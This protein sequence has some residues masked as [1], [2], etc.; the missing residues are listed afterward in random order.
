MN[1]WCICWFFTNIFTGILNLKGLT[2]RRLYK[3]FGVK[4]LIMWGAL[5]LL[6][7]CPH[8]G[9][10]HRD[11]FIPISLPTVEYGPIHTYHAVPL[12]LHCHSPTV[13]NADRSPT[14]RLWTADANSQYHAVPL[15]RT[16]RGLERSLSEQRIRGMAG[17]R[18]GMCESNTAALCKSN[19][20]D[21]I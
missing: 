21:T 11:S 5:I 4:G 2:A 12:P 19:G 1:N 8:G 3:S 20:K 14:C 15:P 10:K 7:Q 13:L 6:P 18:H 17:E 9:V 16:C